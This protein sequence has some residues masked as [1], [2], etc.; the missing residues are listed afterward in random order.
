M[1]KLQ[2]LW[3]ISTQLSWISKKFL[4]KYE[5]VSGSTDGSIIQEEII[6]VKGLR[7]DFENEMKNA[8]N[9]NRNWILK[10]A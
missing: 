7:M 4:L 2:Q 10:N 8:R 1:I 5:G 9:G 6:A 3:A